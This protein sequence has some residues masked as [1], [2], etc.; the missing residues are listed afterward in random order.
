MFESTYCLLSI[1]G[2]VERVKGRKKLQK[3]LHLLESSGA[4]VPFKYEYHFFGPY[5]AELQEE[6][7]F[8]VQQGF[9]EETKTDETYVYTITEKGRKFKERLDASGDYQFILD[10]VLLN[11]LSQKSSQFL[12]MVSTYAFLIES[13]YKPEEAKIKAVELKEHLKNC[14]NEAVEFYKV[15]IGG[16]N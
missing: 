10:D 7:N 3:T 9:I 4:D 1:L 6:V 15:N 2:S 14:I 11:S 8:S 16:R 12:E 13:G 5:S